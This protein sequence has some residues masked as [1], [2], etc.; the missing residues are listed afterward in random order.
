VRGLRRGLSRYRRFAVE[1]GAPA[2]AGYAWL[3]AQSVPIVMEPRFSFARALSENYTKAGD[4]TDAGH[5]VSSLWRLPARPAAPWGKRVT[6][7]PRTL[8]RKVDDHDVR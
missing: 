1:G 4:R 7:P 6:C 8:D 2:A 5:I 3:V